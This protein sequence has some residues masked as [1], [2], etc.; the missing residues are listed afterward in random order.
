M[1]ASPRVLLLT[2]P[3]MGGHQPPGHP[4]RPERL[5]AA[6]TGVIDGAAAAGAVLQ[7][8]RVEAAGRAVLVAA[9]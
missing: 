5:G 8:G 9:R 6:S 3:G 1:E 2:D 4:E 7:A